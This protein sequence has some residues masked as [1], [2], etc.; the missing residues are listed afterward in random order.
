MR[1][2]RGN[3]PLVLDEYDYTFELGKAKLLRDGKDVLI[4]SSGFMTMRA[5]EAAEALRGRPGRCR[6]AARADHQAAGRGDDPAG[7]LAQRAAWWSSPRTTPIIGGLGEAVAGLL[8]RSGVTPTFRQ[9]ALA[10]RV[11][12]R[13]R[14]ADPARPL[15]HLD[16]MP[17][18]ARS[19]SGCH[20]EAVTMSGG[21][22]LIGLRRPRTARRAASGPR[23]RREAG[24]PDAPCHLRPGQRPR[25]QEPTNPGLSGPDARSSW[26]TARSAGCN[27]NLGRKDDDTNKTARS[28]AGPCWRPAP[29][30]RCAASSPGRASAAEFN[31]KLATGQD[32]THPVN[33]RAQE[34]IDRIREATGGRL[35]IKLF[36]ANQLGS[37]TD[38]LTQ[39]R[40]G[41][42]EFFNLS[43]SILATFVPVAGIVNTGFAFKDYDAVWKAMDGD[44]GSLHPRP[45]RQDAD[46]DRVARSGTTASATSPRRRA[47]S[48]R[49]TTSR[50]S[51]SASRRRRS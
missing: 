40:N 11:P 23:F 35:E 19:K 20:T 1:L 17:C 37:D 16:R 45:D 7:G 46:H 18:R 33:I 47:R 30:C 3:V 34:A 31:Y 25:R 22:P 50:A 42:V 51:R 29:P 21:R 43:S 44:L 36:P 48:R 15:R 27:G 6:R 38:L 2:L 12:R 41:S 9:I 24:H 14:A 8:L 39:V 13:R 32:P 49:P 28:P 10:G 4:I 5:L 26:S